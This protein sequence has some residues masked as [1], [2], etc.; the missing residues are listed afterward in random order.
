MATAWGEPQ[1]W[2]T[3]GAAWTAILEKA[4]AAVETVLTGNHI[5]ESGWDL[6]Q[7]RLDVPDFTYSWPKYEGDGNQGV[8][9]RN[10]H[11]WVEGRWPSYLLYVEAAAW[12]DRNLKRRV[13]F[14][15]SI[16]LLVKVVDKR[17][18]PYVEE[19]EDLQD[20]VTKLIS[21]VIQTNLEKGE[22]YPLEATPE[23]G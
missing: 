10:I 8:E 19:I 11:G 7:F 1:L 18:P 15:P 4:R 21:G 14:I 3:E 2:A 20:A 17:E 16:Y 13:V 12:R 6:T 9:Y 22:A 5:Y 23:E